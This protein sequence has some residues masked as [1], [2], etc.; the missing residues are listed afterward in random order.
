[1]LVVQEEWLEWKQHPTT[2]EFF[3]SLDREREHIKEQLVLGL[4]EEDEKARGIA[5]CLLDLQEMKYEEWREVAY[6]K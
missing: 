1:M 4:F 6:G 3:K 2:I 5:K